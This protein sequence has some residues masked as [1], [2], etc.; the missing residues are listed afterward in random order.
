MAALSLVSI[1]VFLGAAIVFVGGPA[2][3]FAHP[4]LTVIAAATLAFAVAAL[5]TDA[6]LSSGVREDR[7]NRWVI[8]ALGVLGLLACVVPPYTDRLDFWS[9][10]GEATRWLG[11]ALYCVGGA[12]RIAPVF[13]LGKRFSGLVALQPGHRLVTTGLYAN[14][15]NPSYLGLIVLCLGWA[16]AF[17]SALGIILVAA[18]LIP[19]KARMESEERLLAEAFG[20]EYEAYRARTWRLLPW[21]Y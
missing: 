7:G 6:S 2:A 8:I 4:P 10:G 1:A 20:A 12:L 19:L 14:V 17:R 15:R 5:F 3:F 21:V 16:L 13:A 9:F 18:M 11:A